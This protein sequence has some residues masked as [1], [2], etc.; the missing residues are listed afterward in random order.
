T[1]LGRPAD[2]RREGVRALELWSES[3]TAFPFQWLA[4]VPLLGLAV[5]EGDLEAA[6]GHARLLTAPEQQRLPAGCE[7]ALTEGL[8]AW[9]RREP[10]G[11]AAAFARA[12][13]LAPGAAP[14]TGADAT[15]RAARPEG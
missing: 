13:A 5:A 15:A 11:A 12:V 9:R 14:G 8:A 6:A 2:A 10:R 7:R 3:S 4:A 1:E